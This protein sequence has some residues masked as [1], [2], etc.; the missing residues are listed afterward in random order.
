MKRILASVV[1]SL[2]AACGGGGSAPPAPTVAMRAPSPGVVETTSQSIAVT[3]SEAMDP[4]SVQAGF[5]VAVTGGA[6]I[7][8]SVTVAGDTA[9]FTPLLPLPA[10]ASLTASLSPDVRSSAGG[11]LGTAV[12]WSF[13]TAHWRAMSTAGA[14]TARSGHTAI[15]SGSELI[16]WGG[17]PATMSGGRYAPAT[18]TWRA[19]SVTG[20]PAGRSGHTAVWTGTE[21]IVWGGTVAGVAVATGGRYDP[22]TDTWA[23]VSTVGA[24]AARS[25]HTAVWTG[26]E[27][28]VWGGTGTALSGGRYDPVTD[29]WAPVSAVGAPDADTGH[30]A[31]WTGGSML[32]LG[33]HLCTTCGAGIPPPTDPVRGRYDPVTDAWSSVSATGAPGGG[34]GMVLVATGTEVMAW[35]GTGARYSPSSDAWTPIGNAGAPASRLRAHAAWTGARL[36]VWSGVYGYLGTYSV[37][38]DGGSYDPATDL[39]TPMPTAGSTAAQQVGG[40]SAWS[41]SELLVWGGDTAATGARFTP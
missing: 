18:D 22:A 21:M 17:L 32:L 7:A 35:A 19:M 3:F 12:T 25:G 6:P 30:A 39:W 9:T 5:T 15:W 33:A 1:V 10:A 23:P 11:R 38:P 8:G 13:T 40:A 41:G 16:V 28:V 24:P 2:V 34:A 27:M 37:F 26:S 31:A 29:T 14:P 4:A 20:A 36:L